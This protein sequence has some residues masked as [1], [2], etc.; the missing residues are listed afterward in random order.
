MAAS[1]FQTGESRSERSDSPVLTIDEVAA[2]L[3]HRPRTIA[4]WARAQEIPGFKVG[5]KWFFF[6]DS[7][8]EYL[9]ARETGRS[10]R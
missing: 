5:R 7:L 1:A 4:E 2:L 10:Q 9:R 6:E 8:F 3:G